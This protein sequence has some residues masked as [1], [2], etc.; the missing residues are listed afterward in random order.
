MLNPDRLETPESFAARLAIE[1]MVCRA[2]RVLVRGSAVDAIRADRAAVRA[3]AL[4]EAAAHMDRNA[5]AE[6]A[7][8]FNDT[9]EFAERVAGYFRAL[10]TGAP[11]DR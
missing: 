8:A 6:R 9:A 2:D 3:A 5:K 10:A 4:R 11:D 7:S 1:H